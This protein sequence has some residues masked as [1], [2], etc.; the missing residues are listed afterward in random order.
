[1]GRL[2]VSIA[3]PAYNRPNSLDRLLASI[4][5]FQS[6]VEVLICEDNSPARELIRAIVQEKQRDS[7][8]CI[9][10]IENDR[11]LGFDANL[12]KLLS[13][14]RGQFTLFMGDDDY[15]LPGMLSLFLDF[16]DSHGDIGYVLRAYVGQ[17]PEGEFETFKYLSS[18]KYFEPSPA[19]AAWMFRRS[20]SLAGFTIASE[21]ARFF[22]TREIDGSLL[23]QLYV[24]ARTALRQPSYYWGTPFAVAH[25][26]FRSNQV[27][28]GT[29]DA[30][31]DRFTPG[32]ISP[33]MSLEFTRGL[34]G[35]SERIDM[36][37]GTDI[38]NFVAQDIS[39][40]SYPILA[41]QRKNGIGRFIHYVQRLKRETPIARTWYFW[42][43]AASLALLGE[44]ICDKTI[45]TIKRIIGYTPRL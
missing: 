10:Y 1:M 17:T 39:R 21:P 14:A 19:T 43:Y 5:V 32:Q 20:V 9:R 31:R 34:F 44:A 30:E 12:R 29:S 22:A 3:V 42:L 45:R 24:M 41:I 11:N 26:S 33:D 4:D 38:S 28:F 16:L 18:D 8:L 6:N 13:C 7:R 40:Y 15:F 36:V 25:Q 35:L 27:M 37:E 2:L 23:Y